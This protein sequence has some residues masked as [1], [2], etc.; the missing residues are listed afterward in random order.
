[1]KKQNKADIISN[2]VIKRKQAAKK[3]IADKG[4]WSWIA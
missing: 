1:M 4:E 2:M 3:P